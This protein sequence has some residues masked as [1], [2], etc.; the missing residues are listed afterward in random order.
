MRLVPLFLLAVFASPMCQLAGYFLKHRGGRPIENRFQRDIKLILQLFRNSSRPLG[1]TPCFSIS[2]KRTTALI[3]SPSDTPNGLQ[4]I[5][6][7]LSSF[8]FNGPVDLFD[9]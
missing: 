7:A 9:L 2:L 8:A 5:T 1:G 4:E 3:V 6:A